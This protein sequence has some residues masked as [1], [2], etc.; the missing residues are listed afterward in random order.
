MEDN[1]GAM[2]ANVKSLERKREKK[3]RI[4][5]FSCNRK[6]IYSGAK[7]MSSEAKARSKKE[8]KP[9]TCRLCLITP[10]ILFTFQ[11]RMGDFVTI[12]Q[13]FFKVI[14]RVLLEMEF[15]ITVGCGCAL[16]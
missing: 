1:L 3:R 10:R 8:D 4:A 16:S 5:V 9:V 2:N 6:W 13:T 15:Q 12:M 11:E 7:C 14:A